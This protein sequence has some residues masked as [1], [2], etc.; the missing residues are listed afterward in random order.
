MIDARSA[1]GDLMVWLLV[2]LFFVVM[3]CLIVFAIYQAFQNDAA[4]EVCRDLGRDGGR[5]SYSRGVECSVERWTPTHEPI[6]RI[7]GDQ[8]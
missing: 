4:I 6:E 3:P 5:W 7:R 2:A 8:P 1:L